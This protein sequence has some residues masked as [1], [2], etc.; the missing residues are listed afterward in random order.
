MSLDPKTNT[1][2]PI[3]L[4]SA[5]LLAMLGGPSSRAAAQ[6]ALAT[7]LPARAPH[8]ASPLVDVSGACDFTAAVEGPSVDPLGTLYVPNYRE[9][10]AFA[11]LATR[12]RG[13]VFRPFITLGV[14]PN[15]S[16]VYADML[17]VVD[18]GDAETGAGMGLLIQNLKH[19]EQPPLVLDFITGAGLADFSVPDSTYELNDLTITPRGDIYISAPCWSTLECPAGDQGRIYHLSVRD[20]ERNARAGG[21]RVEIA[22]HGLILPNGLTTDVFGRSIYVNTGG[23][24]TD[25]FV[26]AADLRILRFAVRL[27][28]SLGEPALVLQLNEQPVPAWAE[29]L[30]G[31]R[32]DMAGNLWVAHYGR[33]TIDFVDT[34]GARPRVLHSWETPA[35][36]AISNLT[37]GGPGWRTLYVTYS[38]SEACGSVAEAP[39]LIPGLPY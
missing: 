17:Y 39:I 8:D 36:T 4:I 6:D 30:D 12:A 5:A 18:K 15:G 24:M 28:A 3:A 31:L 38:P 11:R 27:D 29:Q 25:D 7:E 33:G 34:H 9:A 13:G 37:F 10:G 23:G 35:G 16:R 21:A 26:T 32:A 1:L 2:S 19:P 22:A 20:I 14:R